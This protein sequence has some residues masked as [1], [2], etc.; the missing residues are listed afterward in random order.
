MNRAPFCLVI[1]FA[2]PLMGASG[3][4]I[5]IPA[6]NIWKTGS[7]SIGT[8]PDA[9]QRS[10]VASICG[11]E[12]LSPFVPPMSIGCSHSYVTKQDAT[13]K[14]LY[15]TFIAGSTD[16]GGTAITTDAA[17]NV[18][19]AGFTYSSDFPVTANA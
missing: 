4:Q 16:D 12:Q 5:A 18:Y 6:G 9:F 15:A 10:S 13:G 17:G 11:T 14:I 2:A 3:A 7:G 8:T 1:L 19:V